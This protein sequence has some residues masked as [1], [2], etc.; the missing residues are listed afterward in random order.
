D[1]ATCCTY[2]SRLSHHTRLARRCSTACSSRSSG[3]S[4][5]WLISCSSSSTASS[6]ARNMFAS[7]GGGSAEPIDASPNDCSDWVTS[8]NRRRSSVLSRSLS[9]DSSETRS[10]MLWEPPRTVRDERNSCALYSSS[11]SARLSS[12]G[13]SDQY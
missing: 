13:I 7:S 6:S 12:W 9:R 11:S 3:A 4:H 8:S 10:H 1:V 5:G 2:S